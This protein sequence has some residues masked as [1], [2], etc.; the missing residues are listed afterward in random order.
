MVR[1]LIIAHGNMA[2]ELL[3][4]AITILGVQQ[5]AFTFSNAELS[6]AD[7]QRSIK[8]RLTDSKD[9]IIFVDCFGSP[10]TA[11]KIV[12]GGLPVISGVNLPMLLSFFTKRDTMPFG[13]LVKNVTADGQKGISI[14]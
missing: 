11:A 13:E 12:S 5:E 7:L 4:A 1:A 8:N 3:N 10:L 2:Q 14:R 9:T 6:L